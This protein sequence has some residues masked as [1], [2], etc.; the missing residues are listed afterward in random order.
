MWEEVSRHQQE[1]LARALC[2]LS[3]EYELADFANYL[4]VSPDDWLVRLGRGKPE[5]V[6][7]K[8]QCLEH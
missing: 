7:H 8:N 6:P 1:Q 2:G 4:A 3:G 5:E